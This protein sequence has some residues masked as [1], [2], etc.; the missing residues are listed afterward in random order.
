[1]QNTTGNSFQDSQLQRAADAIAGGGLVA[2]PTATFFALGADAL[3]AAAVA[4]DFAAKRRD[5]GIPVPVLVYD[6]A[7]AEQVVSDFPG[8]LRDL[9]NLFW[10]GALTIVLPASDVVPDVVTAGTGTV[11][12]RVPDH[13]LAR[14][15]IA[16]VDTPLT[17]TSCNVSGS[18]HTKNAKTVCQ[19]FGDKI[20]VL[21]DVPCGENTLPSTVVGLSGNRIRLFRAGAVDID[22]IR[23][24]VGDIVV[25]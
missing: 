11:G 12:L 14:E 8:P 25:E 24:I 3:S 22:S 15:L 9:A 21:I 4:G 10:P 1:M 6:I 20:L 16:A 5:P 7:M 2:F 18:Q 13:D 19:Q 23:K 17:G